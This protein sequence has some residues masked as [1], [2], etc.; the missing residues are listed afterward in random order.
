M[1]PRQRGLVLAVAGCALLTTALTRGF[2]GLLH[3]RNAALVAPAAAA[4]LGLA[5]V[6]LAAWRRSPGLFRGVGWTLVALL[7]PLFA[8]YGLGVR[9][10]SRETTSARGPALPPQGQCVASAPRGVPDSVW[11]SPPW[12]TGATGSCVDRFE[13]DLWYRRMEILYADPEAHAGRRVRLKGF[14]VVDSTFGRTAWYFARTLVWCCAADAM[15]AGFHVLPPKDFPRPVP[16]RWY[17]LE[18]I[19]EVRRAK[20]PGWDAARPVPVLVRPVLVPASPPQPEEIY[21]FRI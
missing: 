21:P 4:M 13:D 16:G 20:L 10:I 9:G 15:P 5:A 1:N 3:P 6:D 17:E 18:A 14:P 11:A 12:C 19:V 2:P 8:G 7:A